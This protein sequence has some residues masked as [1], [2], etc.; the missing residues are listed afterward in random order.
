LISILMP[1]RN[2]QRYLSAAVRSVLEQPECDLELIVVDDGSTDK[3]AEVAREVH[4]PRLRVLPGPGRGIAAALN[5]ALSEARGRYAARC[6]ADDIYPRGRVC[7]QV[8]WME[9]HPEFAA[10]CG[11]FT[12]VTP[13]G[14][15]LRDLECGECEQEITGELRSGHTRT[16]LG[17]FLMRTEALRKIHGFREFFE[18]AEDIDVQLRLA[19]Q[20][21]VYYV[22]SIDYHYRL[23]DESITHTQGQHR[24]EFFEEAARIFQ[25]QRRQH[26]RDDLEMGRRPN[27]PDG[28]S[29][30]PVKS[31]EQEWGMLVGRAW[32]EHAKG[33]R[34]QAMITAARAFLRRPLWLASWRNLG[35]LALK[36]PKQGGVP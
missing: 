21:R 2:A 15:L 17:T 6:D 28:W 25:S 10:V 16:H 22:P 30:P 5:R 4:H 19:E 13:R 23:H 27:P 29:T 14:R 1:A 9:A 34:T 33:K 20:G 35:A 11:K 31:S 36:K 7:R 26:E 3:T 24:R 8:R 18:T 12:T 32:T